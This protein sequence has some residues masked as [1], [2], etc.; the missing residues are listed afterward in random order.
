MRL[1]D[2]ICDVI[3]ALAEYLR[4]GTLEREFETADWESTEGD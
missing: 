2:A 4:T 1:Y 3:E